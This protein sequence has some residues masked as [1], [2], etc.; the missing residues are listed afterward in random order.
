MRR[1]WS[2]RWWNLWWSWNYTLKMMF[3]FP[4]PMP[5]LLLLLP[6]AADAVSPL[7]RATSSGSCRRAADSRSMSSAAHWSIYTSCRSDSSR[8][9]APWPDSAAAATDSDP[10]SWGRFW[11]LGSDAAGAASRKDAALDHPLEPNLIPHF[12]WVFRMFFVF[13]FCFLRVRILAKCN[14]N[15]QAAK[16]A[17]GGECLVLKGRTQRKWW[18]KIVNMLGIKNNRIKMK[19][20]EIHAWYI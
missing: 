5:L 4:S 12:V 10:G 7:P 9:T 14:R 6:F 15:R 18:I 8:R 11:C 19:K 13:I 20:R 3:L 2:W 1:R 17:G 16:M